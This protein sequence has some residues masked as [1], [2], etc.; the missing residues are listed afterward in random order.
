M[1]H[2]LKRLVCLALTLLLILAALPAGAEM[3]EPTLEPGALPYDANHPEQLEENQLYATAAIVIEAES[4]RVVFEKNADLILPPASTTKIMTVMLG[5]MMCEP[6]DMVPVSYNAVNM[7]EDATTMG[8]REGEEINMEDLLYGTLMRSGNDGAVAI[9]EYISG[10]EAAF[11]DLMNSTAASLGMTNT[12]FVNPHG[13]H[14]DAHYSTARDLATLAR[15]AMQND[16][17]REIA[18]TVTHDIDETNKQRARTVTTRHRIMLKTYNG[19][20]N[21]YYY[22]PITGIKTGSHSMA[23]N[24]FV[25]S[26]E[27]DGVQ[28]ISVVLCSGH[29]N[30]WND[31]I[32]L[33]E[34]GF[35]QFEHVTIPE[36]YQMHPISVY[37]SGYA[38]DDSQL[39]EL[40]L[41]CT[42]VD[43]LKMGEITATH[44]EIE[45]LADHLREKVTVV[46]T[47][48]LKA[49]IT[50][51]EII[52]TMTYRPE[53]GG[54]TVHF[55]LLATRTVPKR[56]DAPLTLEQIVAMTEAD[57]NP[58]PPLTLEIVLILLSPFIIL[59]L[60]VL[61]LRFLYKRYRKHY[62]RLP[63]NS[64]RYVK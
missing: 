29:Y 58:F 54:E 3:P 45:Y 50:A 61:T 55:N 47:R 1:P 7:P 42:P 57:P 53:N 14:D 56:T 46:Y 62:S 2:T 26:A 64:N 38:L 49:P 63:K 30:V 12:H 52:A 9:A 36:L 16:T 60:I 28:L 41:S 8:L 13:L 23:G 35:S 24:C 5:A 17:F 4:G 51:G 27:K 34:Y 31:T 39:G 21:K 18:G 37:T 43:P 44:S 20:E 40:V 10:S 6:G 59:V 48:E 32:R 22:A 19:K 25:G 11:A 15:V 33:M